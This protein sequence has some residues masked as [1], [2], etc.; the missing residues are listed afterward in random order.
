MV[1]QLAAYK[2]LSDET[3][4][5]VIERTGGVPLFVEELTRAVLESGGAALTGRS[6]P[7]TLHDSLM[8]R[9]DRLGPA[10]EIIQIGAVIGGEFSYELLHAVHPVTEE[11]LQCALHNLAD[12]ELI[13]V[14]GIA[15][16]AAY[17]FKHALIHDAAYEALLKSRR[18]E[19]HRLVARTIDENFPALKDVH[20][21]V[22]ARHWTEAGDIEPAIAEWSR[23]GKAMQ[24][25]NAFAEAQES[26]QQALALLDLRPESPER[27]RRELEL[28]QSAY[29]LVSMTA[30]WSAPETVNAAERIT[31]LAE[32][33][34][35]LTP[36]GRSLQL[37][38][39]GAFFGGDFLTAGALADQSLKLALREGSPNQIASRYWF[40]LVV[41]YWRGDL[42]GAEQHF[43]AGLKF[44]EDPLYRQA[45]I[46]GPVDAFG[47]GSLN[48]SILGRPDIARQR[49]ARMRA[50]VDRNNPG[51]LTTAAFL[52]AW[53]HLIIREYEEAEA[54]AAQAVELSEQH[55]IP[56]YTVGAQCFLGTARAHL[57]R[58]TEGI[59]LLRQGMAGMLRLGTR[60]G[61][62]IYPVWLS[63]AQYREGVDL[64]SLETIEQALGANPDELIYRPEALRIRGQLRHKQA[65]TELA[66]DD[67]RD[68]IAL[69]QKMGAKA[70][71]L[72][73]TM[74]L[75]RLLAQ[76]DRGEEARAML[77]EIYGWFTEG[78]DTRDLMDAK[79]LLDEL[80]T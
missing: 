75:A 74:S 24:E 43:L 3:I 23:A 52:A 11:N 60:L 15:P 37:R 47:Y 10:K 55:Q 79:A 80:A 58:A 73:A 64:A 16:D 22:L 56:N 8:A 34:G 13:Y 39:L 21:E 57:G 71:E 5:T 2:A 42:T 44:F 12:A 59:A 33:S 4:A 51:H 1:G 35:N 40:Q 25:R 48:A 18:K 77:A 6:I 28:R 72:R 62:S 31:T 30:G 17:Q 26:Y 38:G 54:L 27:D 9:L 63:E 49:L 14:R 61:V 32:K 7:A 70:W 45:P 65:Q 78:F 76:Q 20:P 36:L 19:L 53:L 29:V 68:A 69:A 66:E 46:G 67:F 50:A 41:C